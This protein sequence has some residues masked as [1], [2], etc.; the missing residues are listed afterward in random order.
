MIHHAER[1]PHNNLELFSNAPITNLRHYRALGFNAARHAQGEIPE[2]V[3]VPQH[4]EA[5]GSRYH[6]RVALIYA[7]ETSLTVDGAAPEEIAVTFR[8]GGGMS[9][10]ADGRRLSP[11]RKAPGAGEGAAR[12]AARCDHARCRDRPPR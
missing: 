10:K 8:G 1:L 5:M 3:V 4:G 2:P 9:D 7:I 11:C 6:A 12:Q